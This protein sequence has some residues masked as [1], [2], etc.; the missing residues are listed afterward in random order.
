MD[1][2]RDVQ[3]SSLRSSGSFSFVRV[4]S[5]F[6]GLA[7]LTDLPPTYHSQRAPRDGLRALRI[8]VLDASSPRLSGCTR[9]D[10]VAVSEPHVSVPL[11]VQ[12]VQHTC[13][14]RLGFLG[15]KST[16]SS[17]RPSQ[18]TRLPLLHVHMPVASLASAFALL[19][20]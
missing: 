10:R 20:V 12:Y 15:G 13:P 11:D 14:P 6:G 4:H 7:G 18:G 5:T 2:F 1:S 16:F 8:V 9:L 3:P 17:R 19:L